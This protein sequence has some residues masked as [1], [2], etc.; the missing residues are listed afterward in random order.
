MTLCPAVHMLVSKPPKTLHKAPYVISQLE[1]HG[2]KLFT[3]TVS[4]MIYDK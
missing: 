1:L 3:F 4:A 2:G